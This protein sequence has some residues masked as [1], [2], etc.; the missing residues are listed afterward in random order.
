MSI[1]TINDLSL[2]TPQMQE[3][4][5][6]LVANCAKRGV[7][8]ITYETLRTPQTQAAYYRRGRT[9]TQISQ[10]VDKLEA[11]GAHWL[12]KI[13]EDAGP[14]TGGRCTNALPGQSWHHFGRAFDN[15]WDADMKQPGLQLNWDVNVQINGVNGWRVQA[16]EATKLGLVPAG[17]WFGDWPHV[18]DNHDSAPKIAWPDLDAQLKARFG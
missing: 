4:H 13:L 7:T 2:L 16:E 12:A 14:Q 6:A 5:A 10:A 18:Q 8:L 3:K 11:A 15:Y 17:P 9:I 1:K